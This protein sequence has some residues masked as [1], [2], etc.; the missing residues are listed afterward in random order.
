MIFQKNCNICDLSASHW[1]HKSFVLLPHILFHRKAKFASRKII[2]PR[3]GMMLQHE[4]H[5][6]FSR[7]ASMKSRWSLVSEK[8]GTHWD[9]RKNFSGCPSW[10]VCRDGTFLISAGYFSTFSTGPIA[11]TFGTT[12]RGESE[13]NGSWI[14]RLLRRF[15]ASNPAGLRQQR[16]G[17]QVKSS[18]KMKNAMFCRNHN[19][20]EK[21]T[22]FYFLHRQIKLRS[23]DS[24]F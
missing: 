19:Y 4:I 13:K 12:R 11:G 8:K 14:R 5:V 2:T 15:L 10:C 7:N 23:I 17:L 1:I 24:D 21:L 20:D 6:E 22:I 18:I 16:G 9:N 3:Y